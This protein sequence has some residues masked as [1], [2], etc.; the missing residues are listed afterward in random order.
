MVRIKTRN[1]AGGEFCFFNREELAKAVQEGWITPGWQIFHSSTGRWLPI[2]VHPTFGQAFAFRKDYEP[3]PQPGSDLILILP[4]SCG[5]PVAPKAPMRF[6]RPGG[7]PAV[8]RAFIVMFL[9]A[10]LAAAMAPACP[11]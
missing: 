7:T 9:L 10:L 8:R 5:P 11:A 6:R 3:G 4:E 2:T 1:P